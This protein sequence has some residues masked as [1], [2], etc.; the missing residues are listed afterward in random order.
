MADYTGYQATLDSST[1][2]GIK[3]LSVSSDLQKVLY[4]GSGVFEAHGV[5]TL[6]ADQRISLSS[7]DLKSV[8]DAIGL[9][10]VS[11][12]TKNLT[13]YAQKLLAGSTFA[14]GASHVKFV[15]NKGIIYIDS[16]SATLDQEATIS[17]SAIPTSDGVNPPIVPTDSVALS[18]LVR[19]SIRFTLGTVSVNSVAIPVQSVSINLGIQ[20]QPVGADG[21][22]YHT[23]AYV[24]KRA[25][26]ITITTNDIGKAIVQKAEG[27]ASAGDL[28]I[29]FKK[30]AIGGTRVANATEEHIVFNV[31]GY[32]I[33]NSAN[34]LS[35]A[36]GNATL[37]I[38]PYWDGTNDA[39]TV[40]TASAI[41]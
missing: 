39:I 2:K 11:L 4:D 18:T 27:L 28:I 22:P 38:T 32:Q 31:K 6:K 36:V 9:L 8:I 10:S 14:T 26:S 3:S 20:A 34:D 41:S 25:I 13:V 19:D 15:C 30:I 7:A 35:G 5:A 16:I 23:E 33:N 12:A 24:S 37:M 29:S 1:I 21:L 40:S 17:V